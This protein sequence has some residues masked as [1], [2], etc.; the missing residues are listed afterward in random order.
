MISSTCTRHFKANS[1]VFQQ[2]DTPEGLYIITKGRAQV[3]YK[4]EDN[5][6]RPVGQLGPGDIFGETALLD[7][8]DVRN[9]SV[10]CLGSVECMYWPKEEFIHAVA[11][12]RELN[13]A[14]EEVTQRA[15]R[16]RYGQCIFE[17]G[18]VSISLFVEYPSSMY[19]RI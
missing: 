4:G 9:A 11:N 17:C 18:C 15:Q 16:S 2:G 3:E 10:R 12:D 13:N 7:G 5:C 1:F 6:S 14:L 8:R 19:K